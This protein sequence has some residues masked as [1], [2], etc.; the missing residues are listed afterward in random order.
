[1]NYRWLIAA[2]GAAALTLSTAAI[3]VPIS[4]SSPSG[5]LAA[6]IPLG[7]ELL[8]RRAYSRL[9]TQDWPDE[10]KARNRNLRDAL[11]LA[12]ST[13]SGSLTPQADD[14]RAFR[15]S[16]RVVS[17]NRSSLPVLQNSGP[18]APSWDDKLRAKLV[19][20]TRKWIKER[21]WGDGVG[22]LVFE[23]ANA[24]NPTLLMQA[25]AQ[26]FG[27]P[28]GGLDHVAGVLDARR[29]GRG[30][31]LHRSQ[32]I[33]GLDKLVDLGGSDFVGATARPGGYEKKTVS[34]AEFLRRIIAAAL[35]TPWT[36]LAVV[37][38][39]IG[40]LLSAGRSNVS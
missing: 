8:L 33:S 38:L 29:S 4:G 15:G 5:G 27:S 37:F 25:R 31:G 23:S 3:A 20:V 12:G 32:V 39:G 36:Y 11:V 17:P 16:Y 10:D 13:S 9:I 34:T 35:G 28:S 1:M 30:G 14:P 40:A 6:S 18:R 26:P 7:E 24:P 22:A 21:D 19:A 2:A